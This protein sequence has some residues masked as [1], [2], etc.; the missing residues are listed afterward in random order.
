MPPAISTNKIRRYGKVINA[1]LK[2][3]TEN[4]FSQN[5]AHSRACRSESDYAK[6]VTN[7]KVFALDAQNA[8]ISLSFLDRADIAHMKIDFILLTKSHVN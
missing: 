3:K 2:N 5:Y 1:F 7:F 6:E 8:K 4:E